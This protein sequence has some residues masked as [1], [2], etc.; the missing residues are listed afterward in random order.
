MTLLLHHFLTRTDR[1]PPAVADQPRAVVD[2]LPLFQV[3]QALALTRDLGPAGRY[4]RALDASGLDEEV[5][6]EV[7]RR[8]LVGR[9]VRPRP[10]G[11][12][13][14]AVFLLFKRSATVGGLGADAKD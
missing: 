7:G 2:L 9:G 10:E 4:D 3:T 11:D 6:V 14:V 5:D 8:A 1:P 13:A 12:G